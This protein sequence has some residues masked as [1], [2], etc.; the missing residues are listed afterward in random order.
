[1][2]RAR[3]GRSRQSGGMA[4]DV[5]SALLRID[6]I[7][8]LSESPLRELRQVR[9]RAHRSQA[10]FA[11]G[12]AL[13]AAIKR[14]AD[15][16][17]QRLPLGDRRLERIRF[18]LSGVIEGKSIAALARAQRR[19]REYWSRAVWP[20]VVALVAHELAQEDRI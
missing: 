5:A 3:S 17:E 4:A 6:D 15:R 9:E 16:V 18:T 20:Q 14:A 8:W 12:I 2:V 13:Q 19:S 1:M 11:E 10:L 7:A